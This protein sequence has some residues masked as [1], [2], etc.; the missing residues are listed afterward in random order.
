MPSPVGHALGA[1]VAGWA[2]SGPAR[3]PRAERL[4]Q[5]AILVAVGVAPDLD[6]LWGRHSMETHSIGGAVLVATVAAWQRWPVASTRARIWMAVAAAWL[7]HPLLDALGADT[8][9]PV[10]V[11][12]FWPLSSMFYSTELDWFGPISRRYWLESF[13]SINLTSI[14]REL[15]YLTPVT[16]A[17]WRLQRVSTDKTRGRTFVPGGPLPPSA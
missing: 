3:W 10:G 9:V 5:V 8:S 14:A 7:S 11:M 2:V 4:R 6:L 1:L 13:W 15:V 12:A 17:V 16:W